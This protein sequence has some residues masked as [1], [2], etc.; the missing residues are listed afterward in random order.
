M[1]LLYKFGDLV[2]LLTRR[3]PLI[4][5]LQAGRRSGPFHKLTRD[6]RTG[7]PDWAKFTPRRLSS[8]ASGRYESGKPLEK[9]AAAD[10]IGRRRRLHPA[11]VGL[12]HPINASNAPVS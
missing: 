7:A 4:E 2:L 12:N 3:A 8:S 10:H 9:I 5:A 6:M 1:N 11:N